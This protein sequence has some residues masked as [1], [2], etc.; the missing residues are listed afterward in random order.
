MLFVFVLM[1]HLILIAR[2]SKQ[3][4]GI[5]L[6]F[7]L[8]KKKS[9]WDVSTWILIGSYVS[10]SHC[11]FDECDVLYIHFF[12]GSLNQLE[13]K[14]HTIHSDRIGSDLK[15]IVNWYI[16]MNLSGHFKKVINQHS[17][18]GA[19]TAAKNLW[20]SSFENKINLTL[21]FHPSPSI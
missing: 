1:R 18:G 15:T 10:F 5:L 20:N 19:V 16:E 8:Y 14:T 11:P 4:N 9:V 2:F 12:L 6:F 21:F 3:Y 13:K 7:Y 17:N